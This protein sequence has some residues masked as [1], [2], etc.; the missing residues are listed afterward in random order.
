YYVLARKNLYPMAFVDWGAA[1]FGRDNL[2]R[3]KP[4][5]DAG[6]GLRLGEG[7]LLFT[8]GRDVRRSGAP[9]RFGVRL[10]GSF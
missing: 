2:S 7:P 10:G 3:Q 9:L 6:V 8:L 5:L 4:G 1:W